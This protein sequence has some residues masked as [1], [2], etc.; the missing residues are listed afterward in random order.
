MGDGAS[1]SSVKGGGREKF[2]EV[3][4]RQEYDVNEFLEAGWS[5]CSSEV[6]PTFTTS[7]PRSS[8]GR[9]QLAW[10]CVQRRSWIDLP[11]PG[12]LRCL[13]QVRSYPAAQRGGA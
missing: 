5:K 7:R 3:K 6:F 9:G 4:V 13:Q 12:S 10:N 1:I 8:P 11:I 2:T